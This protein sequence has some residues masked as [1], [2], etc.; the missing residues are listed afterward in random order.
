MVQACIS[1]YLGGRDRKDCDL[2]S[3]HAKKDHKTAI[4]TNKKLGV[5]LHAYLPS[6]TKSR[7]WQSRI[8]QA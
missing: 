8:T 7:G 4:S 3:A 6:Y 1:S 5:M 2:R